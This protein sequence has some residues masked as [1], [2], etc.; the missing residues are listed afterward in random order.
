MPGRDTTRYLEALNRIR[1][2]FKGRTCNERE[3]ARGDLVEMC[4]GFPPEEPD[5]QDEER[6]S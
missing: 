1:S 4:G 6:G 2:I 3:S 5:L